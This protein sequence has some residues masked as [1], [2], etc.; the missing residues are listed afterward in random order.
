MHDALALA[1]AADPTLVRSAPKVRV[2]VELNGTHTRGMT[3]GDFRT[4]RDSGDDAN[5]SVV[6]E[7]DSERFITRWMEILS[8]P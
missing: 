1:I 5:A 4:W 2:D 7:V 6:L 3:V 8:R